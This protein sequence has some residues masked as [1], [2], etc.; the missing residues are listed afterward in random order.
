MTVVWT[1]ATTG[2]GWV[3]ES[4]RVGAV[5][6]TGV[7]AI[8]VGVASGGAGTMFLAVGGGKCGVGSA[9]SGVI[10]SVPG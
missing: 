8:G 4:P 6:T 3:V 9:G 1:G 5:V 2:V 10:G 7:V